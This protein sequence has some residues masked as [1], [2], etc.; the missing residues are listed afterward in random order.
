MKR[1]RKSRIS[2]R[3]RGEI[4]AN[5]DRDFVLVEDVMDVHANPVLTLDGFRILA[6]WIAREVLEKE[7]SRKFRKTRE[8]RPP[9]SA[10]LP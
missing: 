5:G 3:G 7:K 6:R 4:L 8:I 2:N 9:K 1:R 10:F